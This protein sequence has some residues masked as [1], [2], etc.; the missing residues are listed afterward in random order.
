MKPYSSAA[1]AP[2]ALGATMVFMDEG[3]AACH[4][5]IT[6]GGNGYHP[7]GV[8]ETPGADVLPEGNRGRFAVPQ[9]ATD[10]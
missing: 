7:F 1:V 3:C 9:T 8:I 5:G 2:A 6:F 4:N 10:E